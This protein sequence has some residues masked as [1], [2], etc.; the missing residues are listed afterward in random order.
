MATA[1]VRWI[2]YGLILAATRGRWEVFVDADESV[3]FA[4]VV[5]KPAVPLLNRNSSSTLR[6]LR[7][8]GVERR[9]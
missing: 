5:R 1:P 6:S 3:Q 8:Q 7:N 9:N 2:G 4:T